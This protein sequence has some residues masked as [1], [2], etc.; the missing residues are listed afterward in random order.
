MRIMGSDKYIH[1]K[2]GPKAIQEL[3]DFLQ[4]QKSC[5]RLKYD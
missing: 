1:T 5:E 4:G 3:I 2:E